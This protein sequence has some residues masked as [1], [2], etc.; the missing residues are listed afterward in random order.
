MR[1]SSGEVKEV[2]VIEIQRKKVHRARNKHPQKR[3]AM[4][5]I[6]NESAGGRCLLSAQS[7]KHYVTGQMTNWMSDEAHFPSGHLMKPQSDQSA[8]RQMRSM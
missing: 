2:V 4:A 1:D 5:P 6:L 7:N 3:N 8:Q